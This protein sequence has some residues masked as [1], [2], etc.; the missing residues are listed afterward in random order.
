MKTRS[1]K[2]QTKYTPRDY[3]RYRKVPTVTLCGVWLEAAGF[4]ISDEIEIEVS[5]NQLIIKPKQV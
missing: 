1:L 2:I 5:E 3:N 4:Y